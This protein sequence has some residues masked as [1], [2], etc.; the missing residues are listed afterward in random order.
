MSFV[1]SIADKVSPN[2]IKF[3]TKP[4]ITLVIAGIVTLVALGPLGI[5]V[6]ME[7]HQELLS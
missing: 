4:L 3:F 2:A 5:Y 6:V 7:S 1:E